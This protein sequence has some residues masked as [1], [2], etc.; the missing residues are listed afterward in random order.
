MDG[1]QTSGS[2][3][4]LAIGHLD[5]LDQLFVDDVVETFAKPVR[6]ALAPDGTEPAEG[7]L[8]KLLDEAREREPLGDSLGIP[9]HG[10]VVA[11]AGAGSWEWLRSATLP[12]LHFREL[13]LDMG[14]GDHQVAGMGPAMWDPLV[15][16]LAQVLSGRTPD[17]VGEKGEL[18]STSFED[19]TAT[20]LYVGFIGR[21]SSGLLEYAD[22]T[23]KR[24]HP[25]LDSAFSEDL[26]A[27]RGKR[28]LRWDYEAPP[29]EWYRAL[30][31]ICEEAVSWVDGQLGAREPAF[32]A[33]GV[34][35]EFLACV[36][37]RLVHRMWPTVTEAA[38]LRWIA[39]GG[40]LSVPDLTVERG[41]ERGSIVVRM[42]T[43]Y[44][45]SEQ[46]PY[47][48]EVWEEI[49]RHRDADG[50]QEVPVTM[51]YGDVRARW[52][53]ESKRREGT[54]TLVS[55]LF[56][57]LVAFDL[58][59]WYPE[60]STADDEKPTTVKASR[61]RRTGADY[62]PRRH[63]GWLG[64]VRCCLAIT[65]RGRLMGKRDRPDFENRRAMTRGDHAGE[66]RKNWSDWSAVSEYLRTMDRAARQYNERLAREEGVLPVL[67]FLRMDTSG[68]PALAKADPKGMH[69]KTNRY[70][71]PYRK[72]FTRLG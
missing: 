32:D 11:Y 15:L 36:G 10:G 8:R 66:R 68:H 5:H 59:S 35:P 4:W 17:R 48:A 51:T 9:G 20:S 19:E 44:R 50:P 41:D 22:E 1:T 61:V 45:P 55:S 69:G 63:D 38:A 70:I 71:E 67:R 7:F 3:A 49:Y 18:L 64:C 60:D 72:E 34:N 23:W 65:L 53:E 30:L 27:L 54:L 52:P 16:W 12:E 33:R 2:E 43:S 14:V 21:L 46:T 24:S 28:P 37:A 13:A 40:N 57:R 31:D 6:S 26:L 47:N 29:P 42:H 56:C 62:M 25:S 58:S 39:E